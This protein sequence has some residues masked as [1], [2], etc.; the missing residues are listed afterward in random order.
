M[1]DGND[2]ARLPGQPQEFTAPIVV[3]GGG[4][5]GLT[6]ALFL[7][8]HG[9]PCTVINDTPT[10]G[11]LPRGSTHNAR[12][13]EHFRRLGIAGE[14]R[15]LGLPP[16]HPTDVAYFTRYSG[17]ELARLPM[18][19]AD[20]TRQEVL[21]APDTA[22]TPEPLH[23]V[24]QMYVEWLLFR[25]AQ[26]RR[27]IT[28]RFG[29]RVTGLRQDPA[30]VV[31]DVERTEDG[32]AHTWRAGY[33]V[34][35]DGS[36]SVVR[37]AIGAEYTGKGAVDQAILGR[38]ATATH[39]RIPTLY[40]DF[41]AGR[42]AWSYWALNHEL[43]INLITL[44]GHDE[45]FLLTSSVDPTDA[46]RGGLVDLVH[47]ATGAQLPV[48][49]LGHRGWTPGLALVADRFADR[50]ILLAGDA[51]HLFTP[52]GGF[53]MNTGIDDVANLA[54]KLAAT[55]AGWGGDRLLESYERERR[56]IAVRNTAAARTLNRK[57]GNL[58][59]TP[60]LEQTTPTGAVE[61]RRIGA[62]L[63][64]YGE[65]FASIGVQLGAR[66]DG[67]PIISADGDP[68]PDSPVRYTPSSVPGGRAP[69]AWRTG[70]RGA[71]DS[72]FDR[73]GPGF[74]VLRLGSRAP[75]VTPVLAAA[76]AHGIPLTVLTVA[77]PEVR[78]LYQRDLALIRPDQHVAWRGNR[79]PAD[80]C[81][82]LALVTG[83]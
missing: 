50:R 1:V 69:H 70:R 14:V 29:W 11:D 21:A 71:G 62:L 16:D 44:N 45:F 22:Q 28:L 52:T 57:L 75:D 20:G 80:P 31:L 3:V 64:T 15:R 48:E 58:S 66:Y 60:R 49:V 18:P 77:S 7:D 4:P 10:P 27:G 54:W 6:L 9:V 30:G 79:P 55:L 59:L 12:T 8:H 23:R 37:A 72:L 42:R 73:F 63:G 34:G 65:Q 32:T 81:A 2:P 41:L 47:R 26:A 76:R 17:F 13:M 67:S 78:D 38:R 36:R 5:V 46:D 56:P 74:T 24:N 61:R 39:L 40:R 51:A 83:R 35:C 53:G 82:L 19:S 43:A 33:V 25:R 68:P